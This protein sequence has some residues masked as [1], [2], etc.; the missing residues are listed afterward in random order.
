MDLSELV[1]MCTRVNLGLASGGSILHEL[2]L[3]RIV[4]ATLPPVPDSV[5][6]PKNRFQVGPGG[7]GDDMHVLKSCL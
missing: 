2:N 7:V 6:L 3:I 1:N 5:F 4:A